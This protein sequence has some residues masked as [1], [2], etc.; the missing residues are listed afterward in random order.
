[1][2]RGRPPTTEG[3]AG[4]VA[5]VTETREMPASFAVDAVQLAGKGF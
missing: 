4:G 3:V 2:K 1:M 5:E